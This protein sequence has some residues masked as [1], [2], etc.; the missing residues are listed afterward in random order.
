MESDAVRRMKL[1]V[2]NAVGPELSWYP[3]TAGC[4]L[5]AYETDG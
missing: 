5:S 1:M 3:D 4:K 2:A